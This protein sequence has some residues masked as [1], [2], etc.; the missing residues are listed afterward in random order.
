MVARA[1]DPGCLPT[2]R[3]TSATCDSGA[4]AASQISGSD[5]QVGDDCCVAKN[6][7]SRDA[8]RRNALLTYADRR[9]AP[10][11]LAFPFPLLQSL[12]A[13]L[14]T[15]IC[16]TTTGVYVANIMILLSVNCITNS[17]L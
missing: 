6:S 9:D 11:S 10:F 7:R 5:E 15:Y 14:D 1:I 13:L 4:A 2:D 16:T 17:S 8:Q 12:V 3:P